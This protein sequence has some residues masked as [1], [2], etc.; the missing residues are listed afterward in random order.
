MASLVERH[1]DQIAGVLSLVVTGAVSA[2]RRA[3]FRIPLSN[4]ACGFPAHGLPMVSTAWLAQGRQPSLGACAGPSSSRGCTVVSPVSHGIGLPS[5]WPESHREKTEP[6]SARCRRSS[7]R[8][9]LPLPC[10]FAHASMLPEGRHPSR[11]GR[12]AHE[13]A[14]SYS[15]W[16]TRRAFAEVLALC[17]RGLWPSPACPR[18]YLHSNA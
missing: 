9:S 12:T 7:L 15:A 10:C 4:R 18:A 14:G 8:R 17:L 11:S 13:N 5:G 16:H 2:L 6:L 3:R 1:A